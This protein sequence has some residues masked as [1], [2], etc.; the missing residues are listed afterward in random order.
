MN[1]METAA[2]RARVAQAIRNVIDP[3]LNVSIVDLGLLYNILVE[4]DRIR[5]EMT[6]TTYGCPLFG[7]I[8]K[9]VREKAM[10]VSQ[11]KEVSIDLVFDPPWSPEM[12]SPE[13]RAELGIMD[14]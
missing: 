9:D 3:E 10:A 14:S 8:E 1:T 5:V 11:G 7:V 6:L 13:A 4:P 12:I 2:T